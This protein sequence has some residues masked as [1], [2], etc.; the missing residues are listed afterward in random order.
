MYLSMLIG[1][2]VCVDQV[3]RACLM[4]FMGFK[5]MSYIIILDMEKFDIILRM[6]WL[7]LYHTILN[8]S[9]KIVTVAMTKMDKFEQ[10][11]GQFK[12]NPMNFV[13]A[14]HVQK[15]VKKGILTY[16]WEDNLFYGLWYSPKLT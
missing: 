2:S 13:L 16:L 7:S 14:I 6:N 8:Y 11:E 4:M 15:L 12:P 10:R 1:V 5:T 3:Y 9:K